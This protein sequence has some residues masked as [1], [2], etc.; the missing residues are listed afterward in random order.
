ML[1]AYPVLKSHFLLVGE[2]D[3][4]QHDSELSLLENVESFSQ[5]Q[6]LIYIQTFVANT[7]AFPGK[8]YFSFKILNLQSTS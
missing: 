5:K 6:I 2:N 8:C 7:L 4:L 3:L 1:F